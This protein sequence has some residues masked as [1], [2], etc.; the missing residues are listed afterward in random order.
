MKQ[1]LPYEA[2]NKITDSYHTMKGVE[3]N[4]SYDSNQISNALDSLENAKKE[5][6]ETVTA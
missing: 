3:Q 2:V 4:D 1:N 5:E 6:S